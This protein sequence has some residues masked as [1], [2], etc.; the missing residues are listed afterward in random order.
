MYFGYCASLLIR[1]Q[2][3]KIF[4]SCPHD[5]FESILDSHPFVPGLCLQHVWVSRFRLEVLLRDG[6]SPHIFLCLGIK[7]TKLNVFKQIL[8]IKIYQEDSNIC[9]I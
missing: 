2:L 6:M 3:F 4:F 1:Q 8:L 9:F 5:L 7:K